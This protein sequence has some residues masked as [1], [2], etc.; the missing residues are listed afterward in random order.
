MSKYRK[1]VAIVTI[2]GTSVALTACSMDGINMGGSS[3]TISSSIDSTETFNAQDVTFARMMVQHHTQAID[4][5]QTVLNKTDVDPRIIELAKKIKDAQ[6][7]EIVKMNSWL[8]AWNAPPDGMSGMN[9]GTDGMMS[10]KDMA[11]LDAA[12]GRDA[13]RL[14]LEQMIQHHQGAITMAKPE[15]K[16]GRN[17]DAT[18]LAQKIINDQQTEIDLMQKIL[19][20]L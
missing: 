12:T 16:A 20:A 4:M 13:S 3:P 11:A 18:A 14:F 9:H 1:L 19:A 10:D 2:L 8:K 7:P 17:P 5:A 15:A 6:G